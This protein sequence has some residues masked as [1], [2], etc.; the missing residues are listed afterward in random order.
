MGANASYRAATRGVSVLEGVQMIFPFAELRRLAW[1]GADDTRNILA[2]PDGRFNFLFLGI[3]GDG[4]DGP[5][6][7]DTIIFASF[8][9]TARKLGLLSIP[10]DL[11]YPLGGGRYEKINSINAYAEQQHPGEGA[12]RAAEAMSALLS[13]RIDRVVRL[14]FKGFR[15]LVDAMGGVDVTVENS[16]TDTLFP[17]ED[18]GKNPYQWTTV[19]FT[20]GREYMNGH[21]ALTYARSRHGTNGEGTDFARSHRQRIVIHAIREKLLSHSTLT[22]PRKISELWT[23]L[24][25]HVQTNVTAWDALKLM[26]LVARY[27]D[28][29][30]T[31]HVLTDD[32]RGELVQGNL[33]GAFVLYPKNFDWSRIRSIA[34]NP[35][36]A[37]QIE[38]EKSPTQIEQDRVVV[39]IKNG[40]LHEGFGARVATKLISAGYMVS[41]TRNAK[42]RSQERTVIYDMTGGTRPK[43]LALLKKLLD[44]N[45]SAAP[46]SNLILLQDGTQESVG[47]STH[48]LVI[49]GDSS[50]SLLNSANY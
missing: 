39:E 30:I 18:D 25:N 4:H 24:S 32:P 6:L 45:V 8:D 26:P 5:Q 36:D 17:T 23:I 38:G 28:L 14:D 20:K 10:R 16:F 3:G 35:F 44:A 21:R 2:T 40:T 47:T 22:S 49:L 11:A 15:D 19:R 27:K 48:F 1:P 50:L 33:A 46:P 29:A 31:H 37:P 9:P 41:A 12:M 13:A 34:A 43:E 42:Q 7:T